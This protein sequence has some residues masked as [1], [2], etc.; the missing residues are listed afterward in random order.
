[1]A[2]IVDTRGAVGAPLGRLTVVRAK[3]GEALSLTGRNRPLKMLPI[4][5][6]SVQNTRVHR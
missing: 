5:S 2:L 1:M 3:W 4:C 6:K